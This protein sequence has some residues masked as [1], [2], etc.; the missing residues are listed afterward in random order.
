MKPVILLVE[1]SADDVEL[2]RRALRRSGM[3]VD[4]VVAGD[5][6]VALDLLLG[7]GQPPL[8]PSVVLLDLKLPRVGGI[9]VLERLRANPGTRRQPVVVLTSSD[10]ESDRARSYDLGANSYV[11]KP[12]VYGDFVQAAERLG[13]Y[14]VLMNRPPPGPA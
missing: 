13:V 4:L 10:E 2:T 11:R 6:E 8:K 3:D 7:R 1:D 9:E 12:L 5:G 14:W